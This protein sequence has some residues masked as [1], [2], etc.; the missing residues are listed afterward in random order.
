MFLNWE[1]DYTQR[2]LIIREIL[3]NKSPYLPR[4]SC[5]P[6]PHN[7]PSPFGTQKPLF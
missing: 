1:D 7:C 2:F 3:I 5:F 4:I 6:F